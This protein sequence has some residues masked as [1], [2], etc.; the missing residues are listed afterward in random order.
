VCLKI[1]PTAA[2]DTLPSIPLERQNAVGEIDFVVVWCRNRQTIR[3]V[4][5]GILV[6]V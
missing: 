2:L 3:H 1:V 4:Y 5:D 6:G